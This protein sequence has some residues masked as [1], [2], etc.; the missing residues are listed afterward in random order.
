M[1]SGVGRFGE[2][3]V[4]DAV[5]VRISE[6]I[7]FFGDY[8]VLLGRDRGLRTPTPAWSCDEYQDKS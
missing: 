2:M 7:G 5:G 6:A 3:K 1:V 8:G 4:S